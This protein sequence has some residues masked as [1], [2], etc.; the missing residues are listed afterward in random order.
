MRETK[1]THGLRKS[2]RFRIYRRLYR[3][4]TEYTGRR[5]R[6]RN[7]TE[8][9]MKQ[10]FSMALAA[11]II[12]AAACGGQ[13]VA[14]APAGAAPTSPPAAPG[15]PA[16]ARSV[17]S[18]VYTAAQATRGDQ[19]QQR[20]CGAC[21]SPGDWSQGR[22]LTGWINQPAFALVD[23]IRQTMP[24]DSPGRL[25]MQQ[26]TDIFAFILSLNEMPAGSTELPATEEA[27]RA[28]TI[29]YRR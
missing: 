15:A 11:A 23:N 26:Y 10:V 19:I 17:Y 7:D 8:K 9:Q 12:A 21:H 22:L 14:G 2:E 13:A 18:G 24:M 25:S 1:S 20:E 5:D 3:P 28:V 29:E 6:T 4:R 27:L 16:A